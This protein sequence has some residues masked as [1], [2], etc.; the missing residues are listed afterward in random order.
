MKII[1]I[2]NDF[3]QQKIEKA[4]NLS[5]PSKFRQTLFKK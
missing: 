3:K 4:L 5:C 2:R 1:Q